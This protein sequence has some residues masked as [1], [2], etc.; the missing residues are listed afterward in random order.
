M[1]RLPREGRG[2][3]GSPTVEHGDRARLRRLRAAFNA[4]HAVGDHDRGIAIVQETHTLFTQ[5]R[6]R[7]DEEHDANKP[8]EAGRPA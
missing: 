8:T 3:T 7:I 4:A 5:M 6:Q 1:L 2:G